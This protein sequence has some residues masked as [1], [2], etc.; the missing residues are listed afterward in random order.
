MLRPRLAR[1][2][3]V[4]LAPNDMF[5]RVSLGCIGSI[6]GEELVQTLLHWYA[7]LYECASLRSKWASTRSFVFILAQMR[8][9]SIILGYG[10]HYATPRPRW[11]CW[12]WL[13]DL[14][15]SYGRTPNSHGVLGPAERSSARFVPQRL[16]ST[17]YSSSVS[18]SESQ[19][20]RI[21]LLLSRPGQSQQI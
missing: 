21:V 20:H 11:F 3:E 15:A 2:L 10:R 9:R 7:R 18:C 5:V 6:M 19:R 17:R 14:S 12:R 1:I 8:Q 16:D 13:E 4:T